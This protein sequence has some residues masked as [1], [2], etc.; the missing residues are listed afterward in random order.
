MNEELKTCLLIQLAQFLIL[1]P[2]AFYL[3]FTGIKEQDGFRTALVYAIG[4]WVFCLI[5]AI[6]PIALIGYAVDRGVSKIGKWM[7]NDPS[8]QPPP[9]WM[10]NDPSL[11]PFPTAPVETS[12]M[13]ESES[14]Y[15]EIHGEEEDTPID[16]RFEIMDLG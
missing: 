7:D 9:T 15:K 12:I 4:G 10:D 16:N 14:L 1:G 6:P 11:Q 3:I 2:I 13:D 5:P 8:T